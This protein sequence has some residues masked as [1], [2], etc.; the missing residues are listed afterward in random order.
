M[1]LKPIYQK[2]YN[3]DFLTEN[4]GLTLYQHAPL[5][6]LMAL[7]HLIRL[8]KAPSYVTWQID[9]SICITNVCISDCRHCSSHVKPESSEAFITTLEEY[10]EKVE[11]LLKYGGE[12]LILQ[13]GLNPD[14]GLL[15][16]KNLFRQ[17]KELFPK[18]KLH[19][20]GPSEIAFIATQE[21]LTFSKVLEELVDSGLDSL[22]G[23]GAEILCD[24]VRGELSP[25]K[26]NAD[27]WL[28]VMREA[29]KLN[30]P[31]SATMMFGHFE[32]PEERIQHLIK[33]RE[34]QAERPKGTYGFLVFMVW[35]MHYQP[36]TRT[37]TVPVNIKNSAQEYLRMVAISRIM[38]PNIPNIQ[39]SWQYVGKDLAQIALHA[40]ANDFGSIIID[41]NVNLRGSTAYRLDAYHIQKAIVDAGFEPK[42]RNQKFEQ[43]GLPDCEFSKIMLFEE[44]RS[45]PYDI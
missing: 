17:L 27:A 45:A 34:L 25:G 13:S 37:G 18:I 5:S 41:D 22:P 29:H 44:L 4:E 39:A 1:N 31:T 16:Y 43:I 28:N 7:A 11:E 20:L 3:F 42:L 33:I 23:Y 2:G 9:R 6:E 32:T 38:L 8:H 21:G 36:A 10:V 30:L 12:Q 15:F 26:P 35:P 14:L 19:A 40:G 24:R